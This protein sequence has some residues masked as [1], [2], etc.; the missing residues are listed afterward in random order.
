M[1][2]EELP[3]RCAAGQSRRRNYSLH[4]MSLTPGRAAYRSLNMNGSTAELC[5]GNCMDPFL[6]IPPQI[7]APEEEPGEF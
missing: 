6:P 2:A 7:G 1:T 5:W 4:P 3:P